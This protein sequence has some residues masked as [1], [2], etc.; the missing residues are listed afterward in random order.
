M[1]E[2]GETR[3]HCV[4]ILSSFGTLTKVS[5]NS[6]TTVLAELRGLW[7]KAI[8][9]LPKRASRQVRTA[10]EVL[11]LT[12]NGRDVLCLLCGKQKCDLC[13]LWDCCCECKGDTP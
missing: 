2:S 12:Y 7:K 10:L 4:R 11:D 13:K 9:I 5:A 8:P 3:K 6:R 1:S